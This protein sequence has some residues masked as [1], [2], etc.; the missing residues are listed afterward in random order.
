MVAILEDLTPGTLVTGVVPGRDVTA[1]ALSWHGQD[2]NAVIL[3]YRD[4]EGRV[5]E[6]LLYRSD[7]ATL[8]VAGARAR[9]SFKADGTRFTLVS[10]ARRIRL[11]HL[12]DPLLAVHL[13]LRLPHSE[14]TCGV[15]HRRPP[16]PSRLP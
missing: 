15:L 1:V 14:L 8:A 6:R 3:T 13:S 10:E 16:S 11:A 12:F 9:W 5:G 4:S 2:Q 7:E